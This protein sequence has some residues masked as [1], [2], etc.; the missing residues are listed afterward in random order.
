MASKD[1]YF[2]LGISKTES[3][4]GVRSAFR[5][6]ARRHHPDHAGAEGAAR[7]RE[8]VEAYRVLA[9]PERRREYDA[10]L[11]EPDRVVV[12]RHTRGRGAQRTTF[13]PLDLFGQPDSMRPS[14]DALFDRLLRNFMGWSAPK[15]EHPEPLLCDVA[16][17]LEE[18]RRGGV[19][20][21]RIPIAAHC[22]ACRGLGHI[23]GYPCHV[24]DAAGWITSEIIAPL[25]IPPGIR[26]G[27]IVET[28]LERWGIRNVWLR[29]RFGVRG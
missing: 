16:L 5:D 6:L 15:G 25:E 26:P 17:T 9:D 3:P 10:S 27:T 4:G 13:E 8:V 28:T 19:L 29:I 23:A 24:C 22:T 14:A 1:H 21:L 2:I 18:A 12:R 7:F 20:P 11:R